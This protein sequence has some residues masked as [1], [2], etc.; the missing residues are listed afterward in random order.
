MLSGG[1]TR[2]SAAPESSAPQQ[3]GGWRTLLAGGGAG[4][5]DCFVT[6]PMDTLSTQMQLKRFSSP[7]ATAEAIIAAKGV[8]GLYAGFSAKALR[9]GLGGAV[10]MAAYE[11]VAVWLS[12]RHTA[13]SSRSR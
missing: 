6:M 9:M 10:G 12:S 2:R 3:K 5:I 11:S 1:S 7:I 13:D 8:A 4:A